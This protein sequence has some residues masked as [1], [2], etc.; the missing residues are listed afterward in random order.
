MIRW[1]T[2]WPSRALPKW[3]SRQRL[4]ADAADCRA[5]RGRCATLARMGAAD[6]IMA[7]Q[8]AARRGRGSFRSRPRRWSGSGCRAAP[9][10]RGVAAE[11]HRRAGRLADAEPLGDR[12]RP[13]L[14]QH[15]AGAAVRAGGGRRILPEH[16]LVLADDA[17]R[18]HRCGRGRWCRRRSRRRHNCRG[19]RRSAAIACASAGPSSRTSK[20]SAASRPGAQTDRDVAAAPQSVLHAACLVRPKKSASNYGPRRLIH[21]SRK[22]GPQGPDDSRNKA[23]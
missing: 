23:R 16:D 21:A 1:V 17:G 20:A 4:G 12:A 10:G 3:Q 13:G 9:A 8:P 15:R 11:A 14:A 6:R 19:R 18:R 2:N 5:G 7:G 22:D